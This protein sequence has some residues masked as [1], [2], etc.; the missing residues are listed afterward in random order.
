M[1]IHFHIKLWLSKI[2]FGF[3][4]RVGSYS[5]LIICLFWITFAFNLQI[6]FG[7]KDDESSP[8]SDR[9]HF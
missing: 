7:N 2:P 9:F 6:Y 8:L 3:T 4:L 5:Q 1:R